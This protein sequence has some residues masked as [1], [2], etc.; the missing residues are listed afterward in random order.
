[1]AY[2]NTNY[3]GAYDVAQ[4]RTDNVDVIYAIEYEYHDEVIRTI[5][6]FTGIPGKLIG[7]DLPGSNPAGML[8]R[9]SNGTNAFTFRAENDFT[10]GNLVSFE[11]DNGGTVVSRIN[12]AGTYVG[13]VDANAHTMR[14][15]VFA[16]LPAAS[17]AGLIAFQ[18]GGTAGLYADN[19]SAWEGPL[20]GSSSLFESDVPN[21][22]IQP[23]SSEL[24]RG[25]IIGSQSMDDGGASYD[26]RMFF[27]KSTGSFRA[28]E[29]DG[30]QWDSG[31]RG[32][33]SAAFGRNTTASGGYS[34]AWGWDTVA[35]GAYAEAGGFSSQASGA[36]SH[37]EGISTQAT[38]PGCHAE[39][40]GCVASG[41]YGA[42]A[43]GNYST[44]SGDRSHAEGQ[45]ATASG[46]AAH[47][48][49]KY[50]TASGYASHA[51]GQNTLASANV[52]HA[53]GR[54]SVARLRFSRATA[55]YRFVADGDGQN[56]EINCGVTTTDATPKELSLTYSAT[57]SD[58]T[59]QPSSVWGFTARVVG[60]S[61]E[62][63]GNT[64]FA[65]FE[66]LIRYNGTNV[67]L[68]GASSPLAPRYQVSTPGAAAWNIE[69][70]NHTADNDFLIVVTG[71]AALTVRWV[72]Q[73]QATE[74]IVA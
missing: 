16:T 23:I 60:K 70:Q 34:L 9:Q 21:D 50:S 46:D 30:A 41:Q 24:T 56:L 11:D 48:E 26:S 31:S 65:V 10:S 39:G 25:F 68:V 15:P 18:T 71:A 1:M 74:I 27:D 49:G 2:P 42:H 3:P 55:G 61:S 8:S 63:D 29:V 67:T 44:A 69:V 14:I 58:V 52:S 32:S 5:Q 20:G 4:T 62:A 51:E 66:G 45:N 53:A 7:E 72:A 57:G 35:S 22:E 33:W 36:Y 13:G 40:Y 64:I 38:G 54:R 19:G 17:T 37:A 47:A 43:E 59:M 6:L 12:Y 28:G 73:I